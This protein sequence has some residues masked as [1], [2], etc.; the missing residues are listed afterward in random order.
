MR[1]DLSPGGWGRAVGEASFAPKRAAALRQARDKR[2]AA[3]HGRGA[4]S[5]IL[6]DNSAVHALRRSVGGDAELGHG[7]W[8]NTENT[9]RI[10]EVG[11]NTAGLIRYWDHAQAR[12]RIEIAAR[13]ATVFG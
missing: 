6:I 12:G 1:A 8:L 5:Y 10:N 7:A 9:K 4:R 11:R 2:A 13:Y 3:L